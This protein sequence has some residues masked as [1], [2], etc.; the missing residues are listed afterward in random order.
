MAFKAAERIGAYTA[1]LTKK[2]PL[3]AEDLLSLNDMINEDLNAREASES[4]SDQRASEIN[5]L[6]DTNHKLFLRV[7]GGPSPT[8]V[9]APDVNPEASAE[10]A[11]NELIKKGVL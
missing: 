5:S 7:T 8:Q 6:R 10:A 9:E 1:I 3:T 4:L 11:F 2:D